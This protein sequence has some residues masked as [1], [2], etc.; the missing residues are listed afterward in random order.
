M[1]HELPTPSIEANL[2]WV[3]AFLRREWTLVLPVALA[4]LALP[5]LLFTLALPTR[6]LVMPQTMAEMQAFSASLP[7][8]IGPAFVAGALVTV[9][10]ALTITAMALVPRIS[11]REA[12]GIG[13]R[14]APGW[15][16][17]A[18]LIGAVL[19]VGLV[20]LGTAL[21]LM[22]LG[23]GALAGLMVVALMAA[24]LFLLLLLPVVVH[25]AAGPIAAIRRGWQT[26]RGDLGRTAAVCVLV[27]GATWLVAFALQVALGS[28]LLMVGLAA[29]QAEAGHAL[30][31]LWST[32][33]GA[34]Q[35]SFFYL[36][37]AALYRG[38]LGA[39]R[40]I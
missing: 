13:L 10:G 22:G 18:L 6:L 3:Q 34:L 21:V 30:A 36:F 20:A 12:I 40:G 1:R 19:F 39:S 31:A 29:G 27:W 32:T 35:W 23:Q 5:P 2:R 25:E 11:V 28:I 14:R 24:G 38:R 17:A 33:L 26:W 7:G 37:V 4:F 16:G 15:I 9:L 8:W